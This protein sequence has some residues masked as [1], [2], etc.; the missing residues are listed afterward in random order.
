VESAAASSSTAPAGCGADGAPGA[1]A[2]SVRRGASRRVVESSPRASAPGDPMLTTLAC[3]LS[4]RGGGRASSGCAGPVRRGARSTRRALAGRSRWGPGRG[5]RTVQSGPTAARWWLESSGMS[6]TGPQCNLSL[7]PPESTVRSMCRLRPA[8]PSRPPTR[9]RRR[10]AALY[11]A[12]PM[13][14]APVAFGK[15]SRL[16]SRG[17][18]AAAAPHPA[19]VMGPHLR[20]S[21]RKPGRGKPRTNRCP[22]YRANGITREWHRSEPGREN[23]GARREWIPQRNHSGD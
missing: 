21:P 12:I 9:V 22:L 15:Q 3:A 1:R 19:L 14:S 10:Q 6:T 2:A 20:R 13:G 4:Y 5:T 17:C 11:R 23:H 16:P 7:I 8:P 18:A